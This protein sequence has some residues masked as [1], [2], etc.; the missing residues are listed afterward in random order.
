MSSNAGNLTAAD[1]VE[2]EVAVRTALVGGVTKCSLRL[3]DAVLSG[4]SPI[5]KKVRSMSLERAGSDS[6]S[7]VA[8][9]FLSAMTKDGAAPTSKG[10]ELV[11]LTGFAREGEGDEMTDAFCRPTKGD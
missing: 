6:C 8:I 7:V 5:F 10:G 1:D 9:G 2:S 3:G 11:P 4:A